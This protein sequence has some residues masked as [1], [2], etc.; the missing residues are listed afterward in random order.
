MRP[1]AARAAAG[2]AFSVVVVIS[3]LAELSPSLALTDF[4]L[5]VSYNPLLM[6]ATGVSFGTGLGSPPDIAG[7]DLTTAGLIDLFAVSFADYATLRG[8]QGDAFT[9][10]TLTFLALAPGT[11]SLAFVQD[12]FFKVDMI[13]ADDQNPVNSAD[14]QSCQ[15]RSCTDVGGARVVIREG[16]T[17]P[18]PE[19]LLLIAGGLL[20]MMFATR[21]R[22]HSR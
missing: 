3:G 9:L 16:N 17:V 13:N 8:L 22:T 7:S 2:G 11:D 12:G 14:S 5:D 20:G 19:P 21:R 18:E 10:A 6:S 4:D 15:L 1:A